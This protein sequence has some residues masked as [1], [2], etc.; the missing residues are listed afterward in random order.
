MLLGDC[1]WHMVQA[2]RLRPVGPGIV[3][4]MVPP[5]LPVD[6]ESAKI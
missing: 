3:A 4:H 2:H 1:E 6:L 5:S